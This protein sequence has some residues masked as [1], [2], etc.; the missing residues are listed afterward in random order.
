MAQT[1]KKAPAKGRLTSSGLHPMRG[2]PTPER[3][4]AKRTRAVVGEILKEAPLPKIWQAGV[5]KV[6]MCAL[7]EYDG[8]RG[9]R[10]VFP[11]GES[12]NPY[13]IG[14]NAMQLHFI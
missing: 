8:G 7:A 3:L 14:T 4:L 1:G 9:L 6:E 11:E 12:P 2:V 13:P 5:S 10:T